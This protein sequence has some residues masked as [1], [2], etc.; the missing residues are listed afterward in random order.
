MNSPQ[1]RKERKG[2]PEKILVFLCVHRAFAVI[3]GQ[4]KKQY[5]HMHEMS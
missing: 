2:F 3:H 5:F 4:L 1:R